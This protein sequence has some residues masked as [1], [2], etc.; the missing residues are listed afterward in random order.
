M[1]MP[2]VVPFAP[3]AEV[4]TN[5]ITE[6]YWAALR[7]GALTLQHCADCGRVRMPPSSHCP[8]CR[9]KKATWPRLSGRGTLYTYTTA[10]LSREPGAPL[11]VSALVCPDETPDTK[12]FANIVECRFE[13][14]HIGMEVE[15]I[16][17]EPGV[18]A[19]RFRPVRAEP[20]P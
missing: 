7:E 20:R 16:A 9:S 8:S 12:V 11:C 4:E 10:A 19:A 2:D 1:T 18:D 13:D 17:A 14:L 6:L 3:P 15:L 5:A